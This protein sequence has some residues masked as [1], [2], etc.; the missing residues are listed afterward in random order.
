MKRLNFSNRLKPMARLAACAMMLLTVSCSNDEDTL[1]SEF[2]DPGKLAQ[3]IDGEVDF[4][5]L[6]ALANGEVLMEYTITN[7]ES[8]YRDL[9]IS[10]KWKPFREILDGLWNASPKQFIIGRGK[11]YTLF[12]LWDG[13]TGPHPIAMPW[14]AYLTAT[15]KNLQLYIE[16]PVSISPSDRCLI[17]DNKQ[18]QLEQFTRN[19]V[20]LSYVSHCYGSDRNYME[21]SR[22][23]G[24]DVTFTFDER[25]LSFTSKEELYKTV[26]AMLREQFGETINMNEWSTI[27]DGPIINISDLELT[28]GLE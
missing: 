28:L 3:E 11:C 2:E 17:I 19:N 7:S 24:S 27:P 14:N 12:Q 15:Q 26:I 18:V 16:N 8:Y 25:A 9:S 10:P 20:V 5:Y 13:N 23:K 4:E 1:L 21:I 6:T 22:Y